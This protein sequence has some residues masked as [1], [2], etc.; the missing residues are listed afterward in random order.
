VNNLLSFI[1]VQD[2]LEPSINSKISGKI[3]VFTGKFEKFSRDEAKSQA[4]L[5]GAKV[6][7]SVSAKTSFVIYG[8]G[9]GSKYKKARELGIT[10]MSED[11][12]IEFL[13]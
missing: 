6:S 4:Q 8:P 1:V 5:L 9:A 2:T 11:E 7:G 10:I 12:W 3:I 13:N